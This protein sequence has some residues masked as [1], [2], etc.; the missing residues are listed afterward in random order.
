MKAAIKQVTLALVLGLA[1][2][3]TAGNAQAAGTTA[4]TVITNTATLAY[5]VGMINQTAISAD[6]I[7]FKVDR[8]I[9]LTVTRTDAIIVPVSPGQAT[10]TI[11]YTVTN[12]GNDSQDF[13]LIAMAEGI[14]TL[15]PFDGVTPSSF[16]G[17]PATINVA[18]GGTK[19]ISLAPDAVKIVT[20]TFAIPIGQVD[21]DFAVYCLKAVAKVA[22]SGAATAVDQTIADSSGIWTV[23]ADAAGSDDIARDA[24][25]SARG[26]VIVTASVLT[27][28]KTALT[29]WD[30]A[31]FSATPRSIPGAYVQYAITIS[32]AATATSSASLTTI[33]D[34]LNAVTPL[35]PDLMNKTLGTAFPTPDSAAGKGFRV[36][37]TATR[38]STPSPTY[39][40]TTADGDGVDIAGLAITVDFAKV[41]PALDGYGAG[42]LKPGESVTI[43]FNVKIN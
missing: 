14:G 21:K 33:S 37:H 29:I 30:P 4:G 10:A 20:I 13:A 1:A 11:G 6:S 17:N 19:I 7:P 8:K 16:L 9:N 31:N 23:F 22:N 41:L 26:A 28:G 2:F 3:G 43:T 5:S 35:D 32:N 39:Y 12:Q 38:P 15:N 27:I 42:Q 36:T 34:T 25:H 18:G 40:T 24:S